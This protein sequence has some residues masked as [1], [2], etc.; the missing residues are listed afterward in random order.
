MIRFGKK[1]AHQVH[2]RRVAVQH[3][4]STCTLS[5]YHDKYQVT[6]PT[7]HAAFINHMLAASAAAHALGIAHATIVAVV[8]QPL[9]VAGRYEKKELSG[10]RGLLI[11]DAYN[12]SPESMKAA[13]LA[14]EKE[15]PLT[16]VAVLGDMLELGDQ[17]HFWH[18]QIGR[19]LKKVPSL[20]HV[21]LVGK[22]VEH[23][24]KTMPLDIVCTRVATWQDAVLPVQQLLGPQTAVLLKA[25]R[26]IA[27]NQL[28]DVL[29]K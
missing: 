17:S 6:L 11:Y 1:M 19:F 29:E 4:H 18:R 16:K 23:L 26:G 27:L 2:V 8:Q 15:Q 13:L 3:D 21:V 12:A 9:R 10:N 24:Q 5:L 7:N 20:T 22:E 14:F 28:V 25:S